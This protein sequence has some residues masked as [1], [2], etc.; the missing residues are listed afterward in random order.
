[1]TLQPWGMVMVAA[2]SQMQKAKL[3]SEQKGYSVKGPQPSKAE[4]NLQDEATKQF[5]KRGGGS[6]NGAP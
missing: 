1:M 2:V 6:G 5:G 3:D 4:R